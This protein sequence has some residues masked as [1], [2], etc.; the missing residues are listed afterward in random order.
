MFEVDD[1]VLA[2]V[3]RTFIVPS[4]PEL[5]IELQ[6]QLTSAHA[7]IN[8]IAEMISK[9]VGVAAS[10]L[11]VVNSAAF[12]LHRSVTDIKQSVMFLGLS[13]IHTLVTGLV[14]KQS[15][16]KSE[17]CIEL[18]S[19]WDR[20]SHIANVAMYI[21]KGVIA[22]KFKHAI[23]PEDVYTAALFLDCGI[24]A[25]ATKYPDYQKVLAVSEKTTKYTLAELE[26]HKYKTNHAVVGYFISSTW[27]LPRPICQQVLLHH[28][29]AYLDKSEHGV[30][31]LI[32]CVLKMA[33]NLVS[34]HHCSR[35]TADWQYYQNPVLDLLEMDEDD[36]RDI[37]ED[38][39]HL[40]D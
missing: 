3:K 24:P 27:Q 37:S 31:Q 18:D 40:F 39:E 35:N 8:Q 7:N 36:Y 34:L 29:K 15:M 6:K 19:F 30:E 28:D 26:E 11:K 38:I 2:H 12:G 13:G 25:M 14:L 21:S 23:A 5:L 16:G 9:D 1:D 22:Q 4:R 20:A 33:E 32:F 17:C 10:V